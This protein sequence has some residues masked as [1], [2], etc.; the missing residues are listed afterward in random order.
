MSILCQADNRESKYCS[1]ELLEEAEIVAVE[2]ADIVDAVFEH[3]DARRAQAKGETGVA[4]R[5][6]PDARQDIRVHHPRAQDL[7]PPARLAQPAAG[8]LAAETVDRHIDAR[9]DEREIVAPKAD[10]PLVP[11]EA[12]HEGALTTPFWSLFD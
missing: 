6:V 12:T 3:G 7:E 1:G 4:R 5:V 11:E 8:A 9:F 10:L 2:E